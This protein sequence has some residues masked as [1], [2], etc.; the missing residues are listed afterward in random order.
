M[1]TINKISAETR[2]QVA[3][4]MQLEGLT[5]YG[6]QA[7][8]DFLIRLFDLKGMRS[9]DNR[10]SNAYDDIY[11]HMVRNTDWSYDWIYTDAR[12]NLLHC[13]DEVYLRFLAMTLHPL[14]RSNEQQRDRLLDNYN[15]HLA[16]SGF[17]ILQMGDIA[18]KPVFKGDK[19]QAGQAQLVANRGE[20][21]KYLNTA[22][23][24]SK[25]DVMLTAIHKDT[26]VAIGTAKELLETVCKSILKQKGEKIDPDWSLSR[27]IKET[28]NRLDFRP[29][30]ADDPARAEQSIRQVLAG[31]AT[32]V[33]GV[34]ELRNA[35][36][37]GHGKEADFKGLEAKY[38]KLLVG[39]VSE[40]AIIFLATHGEKAELVETSSTEMF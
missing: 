2:Q 25:I 23:V 40:I 30:V 24:N 16:P 29:R 12:I 17:E 3:D 32:I 19:R 20:I 28:S 8:P 10:F 18:G 27:L 35:Y 14:V 11:Q 34:T 21:K 36:G 31:I 33:Q 38:A 6:D 15:T 26:D 9:N 13:D 22:Y 5:Y 1:R 39:V 37:T 4:Q 7:E